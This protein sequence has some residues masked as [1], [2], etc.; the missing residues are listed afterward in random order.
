M[1]M[2]IPFSIIIFLMSLKKSVLW[3]FIDKLGWW[4]IGHIV[5]GISQMVYLD[6]VNHQIR[7]LISKPYFSLETIPN[8]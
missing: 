8:P 6:A 7:D 2:T 3:W 5:S 4:V 1:G